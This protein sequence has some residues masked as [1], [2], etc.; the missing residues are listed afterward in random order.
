MEITKH[1][2]GDLVELEVQG[3]L[4]G[5]WADH[6]ASALD[7]AIRQGSHHVR[8]DLSQVAF[9]SSAGIGIL[10]KFYNQLKG[11]QGSLAVSKSSEQVRK[12]LEVSGLKDVLLAK[13]APA[14][15]PSI[16]AEGAQ[17]AAARK[18]P[19]ASK[20]MA[21]IE[22]PGVMFD[23]YALAPESRLRCHVVGDP[24]LLEGCRFRKEHCQTMEFPDS[25]FAIGLGALGEHFEDCQRRFG[26][27]I[28]TAGAVAYLPTDGTNMPD[29]LVAAEK[30]VPDV[31][32]CYGIAC[33]EPN[34]QPFTRLVRF[35][36][37]KEPGS[38]TLF[39]LVEACLDLA[40]TERIGIVM[41]AE[42]AGLMGAA[43]RRSPALAASEDA[44]FQFPLIRDWLT[45]TA[46]RSY[47][48]STALVVGVAA[49]RDAEALAPLIRPLG[50]GGSK[51]GRPIA[52]HFHAAAFSYSPVQK[53]EIDLKAAVR[54]LFEGQALE[55]ILHLL[56]DDRAIAGAG[57]SEFVRGACWM[58]PISEILLEGS[59][60]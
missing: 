34:A 43:L 32:V 45:F 44:L 3:R 31:Q 30:S 39:H 47:T 22:E 58:G 15:E 42:S 17:R 21:Q 16:G 48:R 25:T 41:I 28:A 49:R 38:V 59:R 14:P 26:E 23:V 6:L 51:S 54:G 56:S 10:V 20:P 35:E 60:T 36:A 27:F 37:K 46:E 50:R 7:E 1:H 5:Y 24:S 12:V 33:E 8:L 19:F 57:E 52:G 53:G 13:V 4:D 40:D 29:Y 2:A 55:G 9:L 11:I 18:L